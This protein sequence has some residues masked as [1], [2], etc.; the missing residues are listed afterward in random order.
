MVLPVYGYRGTSSGSSGVGRAKDP[1]GLSGD[2]TSSRAD[3]SG[4]HNVRSELHQ[5]EQNCLYVTCMYSNQFV[6][7]QT[8]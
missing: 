6:K 2:A 3:L 7:K 5:P 1:G 8:S 4:E